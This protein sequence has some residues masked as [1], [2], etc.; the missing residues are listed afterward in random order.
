M[1]KNFLLVF[2]PIFVAVDA[3]G[4]LPFFVALTRGES[5]KDRIKVILYSL[6]TAIVL[7]ISFIF[8]GRAIFNVLKITEWDFM[9]A[10]GSV[11]FIVAMREVINIDK[12]P[13]ISI[14][15]A[16]VVPLGT[17]LIMGP[18]VL[19]TILIIMDSYGFVL[20]ILSVFINVILAGIIFLFSEIFIRFL[21]ES[22]VKAL[23]RISNLFLVAIAVM[24]IRR[25][26]I[27][28][29]SM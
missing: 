19:A 14:K 5:F 12:K 18:A 4:T 29:I 17:P 3:V 7:A 10:G 25:G 21:G 20:T 9:I 23:S 27:G 1:L 2:I 28:F 16:G 15:E 11:L 24:L 26:V 22:G 6:I 13:K 8:L